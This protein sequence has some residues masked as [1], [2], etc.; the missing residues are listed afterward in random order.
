MIKPTWI[1]G[2]PTEIDK[3]DIKEIILYLEECATYIDM[4]KG[5]HDG[6]PTWKPNVI[7]SLDTA[8]EWLDRIIK[9]NK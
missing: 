9:E 7:D 2:K 8:V 4:L 1:D 6:E 5:C 3:R